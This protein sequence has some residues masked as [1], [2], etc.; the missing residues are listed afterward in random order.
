MILARFF[1]R[2]RGYDARSGIVLINGMPMNRMSR[3]RPQWNNWGGLN[4]VFRSQQISL[5][6]EASPWHFGDV[7]GVTNIDSRPG[8]VRRGCRITTST[9]NKTYFARIMATYNKAPDRKKLGYTLSASGRWGEEGYIAGTGYESFS[10]YGA[11]EYPVGING[12]IYAT[13][14]IASNKRGSS[15]AITNEVYELKGRTY[16]PYWGLQSSKK[17][18]SRIRHIKEPILILNYRY[19]DRK[20]N[21]VTGLGYQ[22]GK[23]SRSRI[24]YYNAPNPQSD[25]YRYL[26]SYY[27]N[28]SFGPNF[29]TAKES[30]TAFIK[31]PQINW[32]SLYQIN[33][34]ARDG[35]AHYILYNDVSDS[36]IMRSNFHLN[37]KIWDFSYVDLG[38][39]FSGIHSNYY[40]QIIDLLGADYHLDI[41]PFSDTL[42]DLEGDKNRKE[43]DIFGY[44][45]QIKS[46]N[47]DAFLQLRFSKNRWQG[48]LSSR[49]ARVSH[50]RYGLYRNGRYPNNSLGKGKTVRF[51]NTG[52]RAGLSYALSGR[53]RLE[54]HAACFFRAPVLAN[55]FINPRESQE[56]V[57]DIQDEKITSSDFSYHYQLPE[58]AGRVSVYY[59]R[60][61]NTTEVNF[62]YV[63]SGIGSDFVQQALTGLDKLHKGIE[64]AITYN[65]SNSIAV[66]A[67][68]SI[69]EFL[70]ASDP[71]V[72]INFDTAGPEEE[73]IDITGKIDL[74]SAG[75]KDY[76][77]ARGPSNAVSI[78]IDYRDPDYWWIGT[79]F[80][81]LA[82]NHIQISPI[83]RTESFK[84]NPE[85]G[86]AFANVTEENIEQLL[87]QKPM[88]PV[89]LVNLNAGKSWKFDD[90][91]LGLFC[92][93]SNLLDVD[94]KTGGYEQSRNG[95]FGEYYQDNL[96]GNPSFGP[97]FWFG[98]GRT[99]FLN[100][101]LS[102]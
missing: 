41:D 81:Y 96:S 71:N 30:E 15:A 33:R 72:T 16:N 93:I 2:V 51:S 100:L 23:Q 85:T 52:Y 54:T 77:L 95:N 32:S 55:V 59:T 79:T 61:Q 29:I 6:L 84:L 94:Y 99:F 88:N 63:D 4:E 78:G 76:H 20:L 24:G 13:A 73:L 56:I 53:H 89:Y 28:S 92:S 101:S 86:E 12:S 102:F 8:T 91:Y 45:Y 74:G 38:I 48:F 69:S 11:L 66:T 46:Q 22:W 42:N 98:Y 27:L 36:K 10:A 5:G 70:F 18:N 26:P 80:N 17:R 40:A 83:T 68:A 21:L 14:I 44:N 90:L 9:S 64:I 82:G 75:I 7:L 87:G 60:F 62:F 50:N 19:Q 49:Y 97:K 35:Q 34:T 58:L 67:V 39:N 1:F 47:L 65:P 3:G 31:A 57:P 37:W 25:Y 43:N